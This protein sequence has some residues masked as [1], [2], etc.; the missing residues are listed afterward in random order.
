MTNGRR[1]SLSPVLPDCSTME[2]VSGEAGM[3]LLR[4]TDRLPMG[5]SIS[6]QAG[7]QHET[8]CMGPGAGE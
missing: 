2:G 1:E 4:Q 6:G 8:R 3:A 5:L 7:M